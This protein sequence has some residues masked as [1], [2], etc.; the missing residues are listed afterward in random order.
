MMKSKNSWLEYMDEEGQWRELDEETALP[1]YYP[2]VRKVV[3][4]V[5][6][7]VECFMLAFGYTVQ[8][9]Q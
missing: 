7:E 1:G 8:R 3:R 5:D 6:G 9:Q 2:H 4:T